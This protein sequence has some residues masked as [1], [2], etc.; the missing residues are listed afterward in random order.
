M[1]RKNGSE[2]HDRVLAVLQENAATLLRVARQH[3]L[4]DDDAQDAYQRGLEIFLQNVDKID[5]AGTAPWL[6][7]VIKNEAW[8]IREARLRMLGDADLEAM[9]SGRSVEDRAIAFDRVARAAEAL[10]H[11]KRDEVAALVLKA[12]GHSYEQISA[13]TGWSYTKVNRCLTEG[14]RRFLKRYADIESGEECSRLEPLL[15]LIVDGEATPVQMAEARPHLRNCAGC[16]ASLRELADSQAAIHAALPATAILGVA[17]VPDGFF[18]ML[19]DR[20][21]LTALKGQQAVEAVSATKV[22]AVA[23]S[24]AAVAGGGAVAVERSLVE[25]ERAKAKVATVVPRSRPAAP[26]RVKAVAA[27]PRPVR[28]RPRAV[29]AVATPVATVAPR[30]EFTFEASGAPAA[31]SKPVKAKKAESFGFER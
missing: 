11:C 27:K 12:D 15:S 9:P 16:R 18:S 3:S 2:V 14:R 17:G 20:L 4:C 1:S 6:R 13:V 25:P 23:A 24:A 22:A 31:A 5:E 10:Q 21:A 29:K 7:T 8:H 19:V 28:R 26:R 30:R